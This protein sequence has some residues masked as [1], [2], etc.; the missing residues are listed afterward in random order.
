[1]AIL[2]FDLGVE[3]AWLGQFLMLNLAHGLYPIS[4]YYPHEAI[5]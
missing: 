3:P 5:S 2:L 1:M 4:R